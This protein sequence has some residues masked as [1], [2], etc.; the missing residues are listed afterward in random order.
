M[1]GGGGIRSCDSVFS[2]T[3]GSNCFIFMSRCLMSHDSWLLSTQELVRLKQTRQAALILQKTWGVWVKSSLFLGSPETAEAMSCRNHRKSRC[4]KLTD[5]PNWH[6]CSHVRL[7]YEASERLILG[8]DFPRYLFRKY[9]G[10]RN[11]IFQDL[12]ENTILFVTVL[13]KNWYSENT[14]THTYKVK[15]SP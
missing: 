7:W 9:Y 8:R 10:W 4:G 1:K 3:H 5:S 12:R 14:H 13:L 15:L 2:D 6:L 11:D